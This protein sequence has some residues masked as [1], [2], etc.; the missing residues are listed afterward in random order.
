MTEATTNDVV[1][2]NTPATT[3][4]VRVLMNHEHGHNT[5]SVALA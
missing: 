2:T 1:L 5:A 3:N 4:D